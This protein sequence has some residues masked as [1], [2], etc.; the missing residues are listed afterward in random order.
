[1]TDPRLKITENLL[2]LHAINP[3]AAHTSSPR[4][5][6]T[7]GHLSQMVVIEGGQPQIIQAGICD[8]LASNTFSKKIGDI[9]GRDNDSHRVIAVVRR[10]GG[11]STGDVAGTPEQLVITQSTSDFK[12]DAISVPYY[13]KLH[14]YYGFKYNKSR[15]L[16]NVSEIIGKTFEDGFTL[17]DT[18]AVEIDE[19][20]GKSYKFGVPANIAYLSVPEVTGDGVVMSESLSKKLSYRTYETIVVEFGEK[21]FLLNMYGTEDTFKAFPDIGEYLNDDRVVAATRKY[22]KSLSPALASR[23]DV[24]DYSPHFDKAFYSKA[25]GGKVI[26][27]K[28]FRNT[29]TSK[30]TYT[31]TTDQADRYAEALIRYYGEILSVY[32]TQNKNHRSVYGKEVSV[33][34]RFHRLLVDAYAATEKARTV[35]YTNTNDLVDMYRVEFVVEHLTVPGL[36]YKTTTL[37]G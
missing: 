10:Y 13:H 23:N 32:E 14:Q 33:T 26:D 3:F 27:I 19:D 31:E 18:P 12:L 11:V 37:H 4:C 34:P 1:M 36:A 9:P 2:S 24:R 17:A 29:K 35:R 22:D 21:S 8:Q 16:T 7:S 15:L 25:T 5:M 20:G 30:S 28:V 6:M